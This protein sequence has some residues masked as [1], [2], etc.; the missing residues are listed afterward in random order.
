LVIVR[1][2]L[3]SLPDEEAILLMEAIPVAVGPA[4]GAMGLRANRLGKFFAI[5]TM[6]EFIQ[7][8][9]PHYSA[10]MEDPAPP[11]VNR[12]HTQFVRARRQAFTP[13]GNT[14]VLGVIF[15]AAGGYMVGG[16]GQY[17]EY[18][19]AP[20]PAAEYFDPNYNL[21]NAAFNPQKEAYDLFTVRTYWSIKM[22]LPL[23]EPGDVGEHPHP[24]GVEG[25][26]LISDGFVPANAFEGYQ[27]LPP[28]TSNFDD[29]Q[30]RL[31][32][33]GR[34]WHSMTFLPG[35]DG[36]LNTLDD[37]VLLAGGGDD[38]LANGGQPVVPS[39]MIYVPPKPQ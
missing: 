29:Y 28:Y 27:W 16:L 1:D 11:P 25:A 36:R 20:M 39:A 10:Q 4:A 24:S 35:A 21:V 2:I 8:P 3:G 15:C 6:G 32:E 9:Q 30:I 23:P 13:S 18:D 22:G 19:L 5:E 14:E 33:R 17:Q 12:T 34:A 26:W 31:M 38:V 37:R 7:A